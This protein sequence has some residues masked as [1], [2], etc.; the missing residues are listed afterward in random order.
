MHM[1]LIVAAALIASGDALNVV[2][3]S[4]R[5]AFAK[6]AALI[7][8]VPLAAFAE[9]KQASDAEVYE[10]ADEGKL[11]AARV[12]ERAKAGKLVDGSSATCDELIDILAID[13]RALQ[14]ETDKLDSLPDDSPQRQTVAKAQ[15]AL[16]AQIKK[17]KDLEKTKSCPGLKQKSDEGVYRRA[18]ENRLGWARVIER[19][20]TGKLVDGSSATCSELEKIIRVDKEAIRY[21]LDKLEAMPNDPEQKKIVADAEKAIEA[22]IVKLNAKRREKSCFTYLD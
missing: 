10:R 9:L 2:G 21:E 22:Q 18:D 16:E 1:R 6:A 13:R 5:A 11:N 3:M 7:P 8:L 20:K 4:R 17:L 19:A 14:F 15:K 12:V